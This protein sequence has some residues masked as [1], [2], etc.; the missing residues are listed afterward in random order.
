MGAG[1]LVPAGGRPGRVGLGSG[2]RRE[3]TRGGDGIHGWWF[4]V[5]GVRRSV[6]RSPAGAS[7]NPLCATPSGSCSRGWWRGSAGLVW[8]ASGCAVRPL[9]PG[10]SALAAEHPPAGPLIRQ[11]SG[12]SQRPTPSGGGIACTACGVCMVARSCGG[13]YWPR[14][15]R[16]RIEAG[17]EW[18]V[19]GRGR[20]C[21]PRSCYQSRVRP[22]VRALLLLEP[23]SAVEVGSSVTA[24]GQSR[25]SC[26]QCQARPSGRLRGHPSSVDSAREST[27]SGVCGDEPPRCSHFRR[28]G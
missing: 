15:S 6:E 25:R 4:G 1:L 16:W 17:G 18:R 27:N 22:P 8:G 11:R 12:G 28:R 19:R 13:N 7:R 21:Y 14:H 5:G 9:M 20:P 26:Y 10:C 2:E 23:G 24:E 3:R